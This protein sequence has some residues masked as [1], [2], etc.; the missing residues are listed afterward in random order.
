MLA[1]STGSGKTL[2]E[3]RTH[4]GLDNERFCFYM[5]KTMMVFVDAKKVAKDMTK[6]VG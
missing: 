2:V 6:A 3:W 4:A 5:D 1:L